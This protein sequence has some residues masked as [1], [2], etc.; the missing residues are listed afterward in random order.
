MVYQ[1]PGECIYV[2]L[3]SISRELAKNCPNIALFRVSLC[4]Q[5]HVVKH[6]KGQILSDSTIVEVEFMLEQDLTRCG[7]TSKF[8]RRCLGLCCVQP[9]G[10]F[11]SIMC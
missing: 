11:F 2:R 1:G 7:I 10:Y 6:V 3:Y 9:K 8:E 5:L 4:D